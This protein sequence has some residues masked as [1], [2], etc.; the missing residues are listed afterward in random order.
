MMVTSQF[1]E[2]MRDP[3]HPLHA[4]L[5]D[6]NPDRKMKLTAQST[7]YSI[8]VH[9][10]DGEGEAGID[11]QRRKNRST[12]HTEAV[13]SQLETARMHTLIEE[14][15]PRFTRVSNSCQGKRGAP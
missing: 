6:P 15:L 10:S 1:R 8:V 3:E 13:R 4:N 7:N 9:S 14:S 5:A 12:I 11:K 2:S